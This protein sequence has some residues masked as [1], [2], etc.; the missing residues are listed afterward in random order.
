P[1]FSPAR[2]SR[3]S[4]YSL[5]PA[6]VSSARLTVLSLAQAVFECGELRVDLVRQLVPELRQVRLRLLELG[7]RLVEVHG[8][9]LGHPVA[10]EAVHRE[11]I[12]GRHEADRRALG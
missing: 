11:V 12:D 10:I 5:E 2:S 3:R 4:R 8:Q 9:C 1:P 6:S 7:A